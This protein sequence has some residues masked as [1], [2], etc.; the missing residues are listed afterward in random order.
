MLLNPVYQR[1]ILSSAA[2]SP[3]PFKVWTGTRAL[4]EHLGSLVAAIPHLAFKNSGARNPSAWEDGAF[5]AMEGGEA[6][7]LCGVRANVFPIPRACKAL[8]LTTPSIQT[9]G[10]FAPDV[11]R[12]DKLLCEGVAPRLRQ[13]QPY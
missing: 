9:P 8:I 4:H 6:P 12:F 5:G 1:C 11:F 13:W 7:V 2:R 3:L 10:K